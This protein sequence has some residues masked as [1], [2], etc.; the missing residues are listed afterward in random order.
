M[1]ASGAVATATPPTEVGDLEAVPLPDLF[2]DVS[3]ARHEHPHTAPARVPATAPA[4]A[5]TSIATSWVPD[6]ATLKA[7]LRVKANYIAFLAHDACPLPAALAGL[8]AKERGKRIE[9]AKL[10]E[11]S[12]WVGEVWAGH[13]HQ[14]VRDLYFSGQK[15]ASGRTA[16]AKM[17]AVIRRM[18]AMGIPLHDNPPAPVMYEQAFTKIVRDGGDVDHQLR[19]GAETGVEKILSL[20][21]IGERSALIEYETVNAHPQV[22][23]TLAHTKGVDFVIDGEPYD[24]KVSRTVGPLFEKKY[25]AGA[26][27]A[28]R[29]PDNHAD[30]AR[31]LY[32]GQNEI[33]FGAERRIYVVYLKPNPS[34]AEISE[35]LRSADLSDPIE[36]DFLYRWRGNKRR[37]RYSTSCFVITVG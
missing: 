2:R 29:D 36:V 31:C 21:Y 10:D 16:G 33:R 19:L 25:G 14:T 9:K 1:I 6:A 15:A 28:A 27:S 23:P 5:R 12:A 35:A 22:I 20:M 3:P 32:E 30:L 34:A 24:Q 17:E 18:N 13:G 37:K 4:P 26:I 11:L 7:L 8:G